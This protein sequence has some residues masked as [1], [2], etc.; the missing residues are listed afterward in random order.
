MRGNRK[1]VSNNDMLF[2]IITPT[3]PDDDGP[4]FSGRA[5]PNSVCKNRLTYADIFDF[6]PAEFV[7]ALCRFFRLTLLRLKLPPASV[8]VGSCMWIFRW[9]L[10]HVVQRDMRASAACGAMTAAFALKSRLS[11]SGARGGV[12]EHY[13]A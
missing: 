8:F 5:R 1:S 12:D 6:H 7:C 9:T 13:T 3:E 2:T 4:P 11:T 10:S